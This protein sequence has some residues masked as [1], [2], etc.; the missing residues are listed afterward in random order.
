MRSS[1]FRRAHEGS[2]DGAEVAHHEPVVVSAGQTLPSAAS[3]ARAS[4][5]ILPCVAVLMCRRS[6]SR[7]VCAGCF[8]GHATG[9]LK[10]GDVLH[11]GARR[12]PGDAASRGEAERPELTSAW[13]IGV[14]Y[15]PHGAPDFFL[16]EDI[17]T[18]F[19][20]SYEVHFNSA[21]TGV[22]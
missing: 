15:G 18:L 10:A 13:Q 1:R 21:R 5:P 17:E 7:A 16:D 14:I 20:E 8:G 2:L 9:S 6:R 4:A 19:A 11:I 3:R 12:R 22:G